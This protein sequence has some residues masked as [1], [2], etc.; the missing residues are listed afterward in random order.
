MRTATRLA[1]ISCFA[2]LASGCAGSTPAALV[3]S[4]PSTPIA[5]AP[6]AADPAAPA[7]VA[8]DASETAPFTQKP[9]D[10][11]TYR[12]SGGF[13]KA[14]LLLTQRVVD[15]SEV[16]LVVDLTFDDGGRKTSV[17]ASYSH[18]PGAAHELVSAKRLDGSGAEQPM[19][20]TELDALMA[21]TVLAAD[22]NQGTIATEPTTVSVGG[23]D[24]PCT[25][26]SYRVV[27]GKHSATM[28]TLSSDGFP[29]GD[30]GAE[31]TSEQGRVLYRAEV[32]DLGSAAPIVAASR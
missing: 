15:A 28:S 29:W 32:V 6:A 11:V 22:D 24:I 14:P 8:H 26:T 27:V 19:T 2:L 17:R 31:I 7:D 5:A 23:R 3:A 1:A 10:Y 25:R 4:V 9:G 12:F 16:L 20:A 18:A 30:V 13:R 21:K